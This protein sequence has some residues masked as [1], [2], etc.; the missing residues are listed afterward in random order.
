MRGIYV[1]KALDETNPYVATQ[2]RW[3]R[4]LASR[5][6]IEHL[7]VL[8][9]RHGRTQLPANVSVQAFGAPGWLRRVPRFY[10]S[11]VRASPRRAD[12]FL[13]SQGG[14]AYPLLLLPVKLA[15]R[16]PL[17]HWKAHPHISPAMRF[18]ARYCTDLIFTATPGS[19]PMPLAKVRVIGHG[20]DTELFQ[21]GNTARE[22]GLLA[23]GRISPVK[24]LERVIRALRLCR[25]R[26]GTRIDLDI[27]GPCPPRD[28]SYRRELVELV[29]TLGLSD[30]VRFLDSVEHDAVPDLL[31][32]YRAMVNFSQTAF[33]KTAGEAMSAGLP[34]VTTNA[35]TIETLPSD[36]RPRLAAP[37]SD[38][39]AQ[40][41]LLHNV[42]TWDDRTRED[43]GRRLRAEILREHSLESFFDKILTQ[44][45]SCFGSRSRPLDRS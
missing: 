22:R 6:Q 24:G 29:T 32:C 28:E 1:C 40:A 8:T 4:S 23:L 35:C 37:E 16:I 39:V 13:V 25:D 30:Q 7:T 45:Q 31:G 15:T 36:L 14:A 41:A 44:I 34:L 10:R 26:F 43:V 2:V 12:F 5:P 38:V 20:I 17:C 9:P 27:V 3:V 11:L 19:F 42:L 33:D 21:P 18:S